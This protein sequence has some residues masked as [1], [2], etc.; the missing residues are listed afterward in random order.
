[1]E[2]A[3]Q[4]NIATVIFAHRIDWFWSIYRQ[5]T[6]HTT[7]LSITGCMIMKSLRS[8]GILAK[9]TLFC[10]RFMFSTK[11]W[12]YETCERTNGFWSFYT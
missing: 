12:F 8:L 4:T 6:A 10:D 11:V 7:Y 5:P 1:M 2:M 3:L 9:I